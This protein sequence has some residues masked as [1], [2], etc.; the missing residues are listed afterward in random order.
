M[1]KV[2]ANLSV[3]VYA[4]ENWR[5]SPLQGIVPCF[6]GMERHSPEIEIKLQTECITNLSNRFIVEFTIEGRP[7]LMHVPINLLSGDM[8]INILSSNNH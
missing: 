4:P 5:V 7:T 6:P 1:V 8:N 3:K 2:Q